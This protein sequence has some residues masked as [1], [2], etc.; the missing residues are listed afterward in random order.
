MP[1]P[2]FRSPG[3]VPKKVAGLAE[4]AETAEY[5]MNDANATDAVAVPEDVLAARDSVRELRERIASLDNDAL[6]LIFRGARSHNGWMPRK[7][8]DEL[9]QAV[10]DI[11]KMGPTSAN[12]CPARF[13]FLKSERSKNDLGATCLPENLDKVITAPVVAIIGHDIAFYEH[14]GHLFAHAPDICGYIAK[15]REHAEETA[16]RN[17][18]LQGAY[19]MIAARALG[20]DCGPMSGF[21]NEMVDERFFPNSTVKSNFICG[22]GYGDP[23]KLYQ[24]LPRF[25]F[26]E[27]CNIL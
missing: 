6:D 12:C 4:Y 11:A 14:M 24:R 25:K 10:Y 19:L 16:F 26:D 3:Q 21:D 5:T 18:T 9:L 8:P 22:I 23:A 15:D 1:W 17:G 20:L 2:T 13:L 7:V 27:A